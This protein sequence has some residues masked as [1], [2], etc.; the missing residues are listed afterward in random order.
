MAHGD[1]LT[2]GQRLSTFQRDWSDALDVAVQ[3]AAIG[4]ESIG[5]V[6]GTG[7]TARCI[8]CT[9]WIEKSFAIKAIG[10]VLPRQSQDLFKLLLFKFHRRGCVRFPLS[11]PRGLGNYGII[12]LPNFYRLPYVNEGTP[13]VN[14]RFDAQQECDEIQTPR[15]GL[16]SL[17]TEIRLKIYAMVL[18]R[19]ERTTRMGLLQEDVNGAEWGDPYAPGEAS[20]TYEVTSSRRSPS[21]SLPPSWEPPV[22]KLSIACTCRMMRDEALDLLY[23]QTTFQ[24]HGIEGTKQMHLFLT[25]VGAAARQMITSVDVEC[26]TCEDAAAFALL[27]TCPRLRSI[28][29]RLPRQIL[30]LPQS[31]IWVTE[32]VDCMLSLRAL[33]Y[34]VIADPFQYQTWYRNQRG[35]HTCIPPSM[36]RINRSPDAELVIRML[37]RPREP[38]S[39]L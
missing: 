1:G 7:V 33:T 36:C 11:L 19:L 29:L 32:C 20:S 30:L 28:T 8:S 25:T 15:V 3:L 39:S 18:P 37:T 9:G 21:P 2:Y 12:G 24:F 22:S 4:Y 14:E 26:G 27:S 35:L 23:S 17:P 31:P 6:C 13:N 5:V 10:N 34:V 38:S 16:F